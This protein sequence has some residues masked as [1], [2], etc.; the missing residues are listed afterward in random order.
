MQVDVGFGDAVVPT[1]TWIDDPQLLDFGQP[2]LLG[3]PAAATLAEKLHAVV[4]LGFA[5]SRMKDY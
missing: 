3:Y 5:N 4:V 2:R 1:P